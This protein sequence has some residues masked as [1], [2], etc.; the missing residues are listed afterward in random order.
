[1]AYFFAAK[2]GLSLAYSVGHITLVWPPAGIALASMLLWGFR[3]WPAIF[4][5]AFAVNFSTDGVFLSAFGIAVGNTAAAFLGTVLLRK[6]TGWS[7]SFSAVSDYLWFILLGAAGSTLISAFF[8][9]S[10]LALS[11]VISVAS[12]GDFFS[13]FRIWWVG[14]ITGVLVFAPVFLVWPHALNI[15]Q[16]KKRLLEICALFL[17]S[18][19]ASL[20][21][22]HPATHYFIAVLVPLA[23]W[24]AVRFHQPGVAV[25]TLFLLFVSIFATIGGFGL[26]SHVGTPEENL[27]FSQIFLD[28]ISIG[29]MLIALSVFERE[30]TV[31]EWK[32][33]SLALHEEIADQSEKLAAR[34]EELQGYIDH[35][36]LFSAKIA[37]DGTILV[38]SKS[39]KIASGISHKELMRTNFVDGQWWG[40]NSEAQA[41]IR[42]AFQRAIL[43]EVIRYDEQILV[44]GTTRIWISLGLVPVF[45][46][47]GKID[48][49]IAERLYI[50][51]IKKI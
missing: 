43:G 6:I 8:G 7:Q 39:A 9:V 49:I 15:I 3:V 11:H 2:L 32:K 35:M 24:A 26:F 13:F 10:S 31:E 27:L 25:M 41:R 37:L 50:T 30:K 47:D 4:L 45:K 17:T 40:L 29:S 34:A 21:I 23:L 12:W 16:D 19:F 44:F 1:M 33:L 42:D 38:A 14:D 51:E 20:F 46:K 5:S 18:V 48:F 22:F 28:I 36:S